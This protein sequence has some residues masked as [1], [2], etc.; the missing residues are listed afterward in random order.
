M[1]S[2]HCDAS[3]KGHEELMVVAGFLGFDSEWKTFV[4]RW[5]ATLHDFGITYFHMREF[6]HSTGQFRHLKG[7]ED[8]RI[9][10]FR[11]VTEI[12]SSHANYWIGACLPMDVYSRVDADFK[13]HEAF[14]PYPFCAM[15]CVQLIQVWLDTHDLFNTAVTFVFE[16]GDE[17]HGQ[18][19]AVVRKHV[20]TVP[21][22]KT[23]Q[24]S[25]PLQ[26][27]DILAY[28]LL[29][30]HRQFFLNPGKLFERFR[31]SF[32]LFRNIPNYW[33]PVQEEQLRVLCRLMEIPRRR[34]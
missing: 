32:T 8:K 6:A 17:H 1:L 19:D 24:E 22:F 15:A 26:A 31:T 34:G 10:L 29:K 33:G 21:L 16:S 14:H 2:L 5:N 20:E 3:G 13:L 4:P 25:A 12:I 28:E 27:A 7:K 18:L 11:R 9:E 30:V 23:K